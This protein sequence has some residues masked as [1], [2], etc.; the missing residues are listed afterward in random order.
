V[1]GESEA[2]RDARLM[3]LAID[4]ARRGRPS[5]NPHVGAV[6]SDDQGRVVATGHHERAGMA[7][8]EVDAI[9]RAERTDGM[10]LHVTL[11][12]CNHHG[13][14][15]PCTEAVIAAGFRRVVVGS[16]DPAPHV[17]GAIDRLRAA[18]LEVKHGVLKRECDELI[19]DFAKHIATGLP[20]VVLKAAV[21]LDGRMATRTGDSQWITGVLAR[22][23]AHRQRDRADAVL[24]G[25]GT[26]LADDP[27]LDVRHVAGVDPLRIV[28]DRTLRTPESA[29]VLTAEGGECWILHG[30]AASAD[31]RRILADAGAVLLEV[32][33]RADGAGLDLVDCLRALGARD[34]VR[35]LVEGGP[36]VHGALLDEGLADRAE[37][38]VAP[39]I[40]GDAGA[41]GLADGG[42]RERM[43]EAWQV[44]D[45]TV[46]RLGD[47]IWISGPLAR[48]D[49]GKGN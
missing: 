27:R 5:P 39:R 40:L 29:K 30:S 37:I 19:A 48:G 8:A 20:Y 33:E 35:L 18:G 25:V 28:L 34:V 32:P 15:G 7:H 16:V 14:T 1:E 24:V 45:P 9:A 36:R 21:T 13:R 47:D 12:P 3:A 17:P 23:E 2:A 26:V 42:P 41:M 31:R 22:T 4:A 46:R 44:T 10:T 49:E 11:E 6:V 43:A 38:F